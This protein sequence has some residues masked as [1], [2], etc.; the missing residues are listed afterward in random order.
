MPEVKDNHFPPNFHLF[1]RKRN[2]ADIRLLLDERRT[3][4]I[5]DSGKSNPRALITR[6]AP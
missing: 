5:S 6:G 2:M 4:A 3:S 1:I